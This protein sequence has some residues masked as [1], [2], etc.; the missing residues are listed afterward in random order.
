MTLGEFVLRVRRRESPFYD[1]LYRMGQSVRR[2]ELPEMRFL[3]KVLY[4]ERAVRLALWRNVVRT[5]YHQPVFKA[6]CDEVGKGLYVYGGIPQVMGHL[7]LILGERVI[8][9][10]VTTFV[11]SKLVDAP[12]LE[13]GDGSHI[14][15]QVTITV[16][17]RVTIGKHVMV[18]NRCTIL[19][20]DMH[21]LDPIR[22]RSEPEP[23]SSLRPLT[24]E[25]D[26]YIATGSTVYKGVTIG[27]AAV[28]A[29]GS[30]V[31]KNVPPYTVVA[32]NPARV[33]WRIPKPTGD[34]A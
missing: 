7:R 8:I 16:G 31:T 17:P 5:V 24:I 26:V 27:R 13:V 20:A 30:V 11:G 3:Y 19:G 33:I 22:R 2:F 32:G 21:P 4:H 18:A 9:S 12:T 23:L 10:G 1:R 14:G 29:A 6:R 25:D 15:Y 28:V 34:N